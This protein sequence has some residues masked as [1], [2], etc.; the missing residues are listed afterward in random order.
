MGKRGNI[1]FQGFRAVQDSKAIKK[2]V[3]KRIGSKFIEYFGRIVKKWYFDY[4]KL[5]ISGRGGGGRIRKTFSFTLNLIFGDRFFL[6]PKY[7]GNLIR[8]KEE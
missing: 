3:G 8:E 4:G 2:K 7:V 1:S 6:F 5:L